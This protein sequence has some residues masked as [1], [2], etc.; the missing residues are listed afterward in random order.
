MKKQ[1]VEMKSEAAEAEMTH[2]LSKML[3]L[4]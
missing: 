2:V 1:K 4:F 3:T